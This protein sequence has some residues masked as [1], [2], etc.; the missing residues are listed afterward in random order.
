MDRLLD[1]QIVECSCRLLDSECG[2]SHDVNKELLLSWL[3]SFL[4][5]ASDE[6]FSRLSDSALLG[7]SNSKNND[8][9][10]GSELAIIDSVLFGSL[11]ELGNIDS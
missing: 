4:D 5:G 2:A 3:S 10:E 6:S 7:S 8:V 9:D 1:K 11:D